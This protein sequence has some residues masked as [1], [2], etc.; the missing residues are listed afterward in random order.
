VSAAEY[1]QHLAE[2]IHKLVENLKKKRYRA[3]MVRRRYIPKGEGK[4]R[5][6]GIPA[7]ED[8]LLQLAVERILEAIYE[9]DFYR[10]S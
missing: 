7:V 9:Q 6:L 3:K 2:H 4:T 8:K 10:C 5:P 1:E